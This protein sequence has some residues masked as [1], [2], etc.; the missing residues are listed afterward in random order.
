M[1]NLSTSTLRN[2]FG[3]YRTRTDESEALVATADDLAHG[4]IDD[5][6]WVGLRQRRPV[7]GR[8]AEA[9]QRLR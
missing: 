1:L 3:S 7:D 8:P 2:R 6:G 5:A 4:T 9:D